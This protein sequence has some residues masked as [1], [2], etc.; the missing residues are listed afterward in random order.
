MHRLTVKYL[1]E[2]AR[3]MKGKYLVYNNKSGDSGLNKFIYLHCDNEY[4]ENV[5]DINVKNVLFVASQ[6]NSI[7]LGTI[8][9][10]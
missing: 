6:L 3:N 4:W 1:K 7:N 10:Y 2:T 9:E 5:I 8:I